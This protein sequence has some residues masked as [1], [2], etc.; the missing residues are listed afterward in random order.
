MGEGWKSQYKVKLLKNFQEK[1][2]Y[3]KI[4]RWLLLLLIFTLVE[5]KI[6]NR[7]DK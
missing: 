7:K 3:H 4:G 1:Y 6:S 2:S 5:E